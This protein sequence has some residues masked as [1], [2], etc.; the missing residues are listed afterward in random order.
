MISFNSR[1]YERRRVYALSARCRFLAADA[2]PQQSNI[3]HAELECVQIR[4]HLLERRPI[5]T[6]ACMDLETRV[7]DQRVLQTEP[8]WTCTQL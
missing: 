4:N 8:K 5:S 6:D 3:S 7:A 2:R 1:G